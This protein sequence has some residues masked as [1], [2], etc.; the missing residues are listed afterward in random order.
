KRMIGAWYDEMLS[1][2]AGLA[3][4]PARTTYAE[5]IHWVYGVVLED[6]VPFDA[7]GAM[8]RLAAKGIETRAFF[9]PM[10]E[11]PVL[12]RMG[13][14]DGVSCPVAERI[15]RRGFYLPSGVALTQNQAER[16]VQALRQVLAES[17][18]NRQ[19][20]YSLCS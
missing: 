1:E 6:S 5:N 20:E 11:Q 2:V 4:L 8:A 16:V 14:F 17:S 13:L 15:A 18:A 9:W 3:R 19:E 10:H 12:R 7:E